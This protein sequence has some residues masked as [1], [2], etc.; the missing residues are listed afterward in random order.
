MNVDPIPGPYCIDGG[1]TPVAE[2]L[3]IELARFVDMFCSRHWAPL[4]RIP[5]TPEW[6][7][8]LPHPKWRVDELRAINDDYGGWESG[9][10]PTKKE[11]SAIDFFL[12]NEHYPEYKEARGINSRSDAFKV[13]SGP[14][15]SAI[16]EQVYKLPFFVKHM[17][18]FEKHQR[19]AALPDAKCYATDF[20]AFESHM[21]PLVMAA[22]E[23]RIYQYF[24]QNFPSLSQ[25]ICMTI[26]G[27]NKLRHSSG[28]TATLFGRRMSGDMCTS[29]GNGLTNLMLV[30]F[31]VHRKTGNYN[32]LQGLVEGD[33]GLFVSPCPL[34]VADYAQLGFTIKIEE[35]EHPSQMA[36]CQQYFVTPGQTVKHIQRVIADFGWSHSCIGAGVG[37]RTQ[38][39]RAKA[40]S[41][42]AAL[43]QCPV[44]R[45]IADRALY[46]TRGVK[47]RHEWDWY[48]P[49]CPDEHKAEPFNPT[50][51]T[52]ELY[53]RLT[54]ITPALQL[55][56]EDDI[57]AGKN[58]DDVLFPT[59]VGLPH[60]GQHHQMS[61]SLSG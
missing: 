38:L 34:T 10:V 3:F 35:G 29:L 52:R 44:T 4:N 11:K 55:T 47:A 53:F 59:F 50:A 2:K 39:L 45:A 9:W 8:Q 30:L 57:R 18:D 21:T 28:V 48:H 1:I 16:E 24:L 14:A 25:N 22:I 41:S 7:D 20:T 15:F 61:V 5:S 23:C 6:L 46:L 32:L 40:L 37:V 54:G 12:K 36:F 27:K 51:A 60:F 58:L 42:L 33:D 49:V 19:I 56:L 26:M 31:I 13:F 17:T 43:P